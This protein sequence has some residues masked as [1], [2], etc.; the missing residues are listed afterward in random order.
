MK[1]F[2]LSIFLLVIGAF[3]VSAQDYIETIA[4]KSCTCLTQIDTTASQSE[5]N[6]QLGLCMIQASTPFEKELKKKA[7][8]D[9]SALDDNTGEQLGLLIAP[10][11]LIKCP[12]LML[13]LINS[14]KK[15]KEKNLSSSSTNT[16]KGVITDLQSNQFVSISVKNN[17]GPDQKFYWFAYFKGSE[18]LK[19]GIS[20][21]KD[22]TV[23][24]S[25]TE[26]DYYNPAIKDYMKYKVIT[27]LSVK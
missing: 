12:A 2:A 3:S 4:E 26:N 16:Y 13:R 17:K 10:K 9:I 24:V 1:K 15:E 23:E 14:T 5:I 20:G 6:T 25:Y 7:H 27:A 19:D 22:K 11:M 8:I 18:L 21:L